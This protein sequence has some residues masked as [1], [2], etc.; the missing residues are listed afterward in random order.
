MVKNTKGGSS[1]KKLARKKEEDAKT[2]KVDLDVDLTQMLI[3]SVDKNIGTCFTARLVHTDFPGKEYHDKE[4]KVLH[5]RGRGAK[6]TYD[7]TQSRLA[8]V[9]L[10]EF[11]L[12][13]GCIGVVEEF[14]QIDHLNAYLV[15]KLISKEVYERL[16]KIMTI[17]VEEIHE[18]H[19]GGFEFDRGGTISEVNKKDK[20]EDSDS[21]SE[22][23]IND[24]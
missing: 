2:I 6:K 8:L 15:N 1:H 11:K 17:N 13:S 7:R 9:S 23:N 22:V 18:E 12:Q 3:V 20:K 24:I 4:L 10:S 14:L 5:Q 19:E 16:Q 21:D